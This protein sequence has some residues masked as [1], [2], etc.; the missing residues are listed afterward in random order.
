MFTSNSNTTQAEFDVDVATAALKAEMALNE[1][2]KLRWHLRDLNPDQA[3]EAK[4]RDTIN[5][6][7][8]EASDYRGYLYGCHRHKLWQGHV[9]IGCLEEDLQRATKALRQWRDEY[10]RMMQE[11]REIGY[12]EFQVKASMAAETLEFLKTFDHPPK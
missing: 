4:M 12:S 2:G 9:C 11:V 10:L 5:T 3:R 6:L 1:S 7:V 8:K